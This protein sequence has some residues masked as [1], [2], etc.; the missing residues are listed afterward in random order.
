MHGNILEQLPSYTKPYRIP[1]SCFYVDR[2][3][4]TSG[5]GDATQSIRSV[6]DN[7]VYQRI[8]GLS[9]VLS[10]AIPLFVES[11]SESEE[12]L[13][14]ILSALEK[15]S[16]S[17]ESDFYTKNLNDLSSDEKIGNRPFQASSPFI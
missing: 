7:P 12:V 14:V 1:V 3:S 16:G 11:F 6:L 9:R 5:K 15:I 13:I 10:Q 2:I 4:L 17:I 8:A